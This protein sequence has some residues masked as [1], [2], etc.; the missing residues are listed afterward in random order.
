MSTIELAWAITSYASIIAIMLSTGIC[1]GC[2]VRPYM[3]SKKSAISVGA[4]YFTVMLVLYSIPSHFDNFNAYTIGILAAFVVM[5]IEERRNIEQKIFLAVTFFSLRWL[6]I[7]MSIKVDGILYDKVILNNYLVENIWL[8]YGVYV[9]VTVVEIGIS[10]AFMMVVIYFLNR[11]FIYKRANMKKTELLMLIM[12][13]LSAMTGYGILQFY[14]TIYEQNTGKRLVSVY[15]IYEAFSFLDYA[16]SIISILV[17]VIMFQNLKARQEETAGQK[18][19]QS[20]IADMKKHI[21]E[22]EKLHRD[23]R[24]LRHDMGNHIQTIEHL[25]EHNEVEEAVKYTAD[26]KETWQGIVPAVKTGNP[27]TDV[28]LLEKKKEAE[29]KNIQLVCD[30]HYPQNSNINAFDISIILNNALDNSLESACGKELY[31][32]VSSYRKRNIFMI[33]IENSFDGKV[34]LDE[35]SRLPVSTKKGIEHGLG[36][37]NIRRATQKY[38]GDIAFE[39]EDGKVIVTAM[40]QME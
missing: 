10:F 16:V 2:F 38:L 25:I 22:V 3:Q 29:E 27:V 21:S 23:I 1:F 7:A 9:V 5:C 37:I 13:S 11:A 32:K 28:I 31:I 18:L 35:D 14:Q 24:L 8:Q 12:P 26:L 30:F 19:L 40:L 6:A 34:I 17:M 15:G 33:V 36:L 4:V 20:Q 39:Q